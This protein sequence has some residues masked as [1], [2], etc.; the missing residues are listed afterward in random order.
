[1]RLLRDELLDFARR[2]GLRRGVEAAAIIKATRAVLAE[3]LPTAMV[4]DTTVTSYHDGVV[5]VTA[6]SGVIL[7]TLHQH[8]QVVCQA[9]QKRLGTN[10]VEHVRIIG[11]SY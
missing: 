10:I 1:M 11:S 5:T 8:R 7:S 4:K 3:T 9:L 6:S 2:K